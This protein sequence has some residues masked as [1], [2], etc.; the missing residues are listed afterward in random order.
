MNNPGFKAQRKRLP[1]V[2]FDGI[3]PCVTLPETIPITEYESRARRFVH[4]QRLRV[5][6]R[7]DPERRLISP[8]PGEIRTTPPQRNWTES[9]PVDIDQ[10][11]PYA[12]KLPAVQNIPRR[13]I[14]MVNP[15]P[16]QQGRITT[17]CVENIL[18]GLYRT[19]ADLIKRMER[20]RYLHAN[21]ITPFQ[22][23]FV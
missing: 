13:I 7:H 10:D 8:Y 16:M 17:Q 1:Q 22:Q 21:E 12:V 6:L 14:L 4:A 5:T 19:L 23:A 18:I 3:F 20:I 9:H 15:F 2:K 11:E